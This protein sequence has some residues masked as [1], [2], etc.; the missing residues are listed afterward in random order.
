LAA[1]ESLGRESTRLTF[2]LVELSV[3][4]PPETHLLSLRA[5]GDTAVVEAAGGRAGDALAALRAAPTLRDVRIEGPIE[6]DMEDGA[7]SQERFTLSALL[8]R[9]APVRTP[10]GEDGP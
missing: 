5:A 8:S 9:S 10:D 7:T 1:L 6:R 4:L 3:L 2:S